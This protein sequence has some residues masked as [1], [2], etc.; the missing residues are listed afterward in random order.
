MNTF[1]EIIMKIA[2]CKQVSCFTKAFDISYLE[3]GICW[4]HFASEVI[5]YYGFV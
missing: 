1:K 2:H 3:L 4:L 5:W